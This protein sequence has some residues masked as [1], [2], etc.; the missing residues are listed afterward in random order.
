MHRLFFSIAL[1]LSTMV[2]SAFVAAA[3]ADEPTVLATTAYNAELLVEIRHEQTQ[4]G[5]VQVTAA[6]M[7]ADGAIRSRSVG[8]FPVESGSRNRIG[9]SV[10][11]PDG[12][13]EQKTDYLVLKIS[14]GKEVSRK[15]IPWRHRWPAVTS[16]SPP[17][18]SKG[19]Q[20]MAHGVQQRRAIESLLNEGDIQRIEGLATDW[21]NSS[22]HD[23]NGD[24]SLE[25]LVPTIFRY[26][27]RQDQTSA[28]S[29]VESWKKSFPNS[30]VVALSEAALWAANAKKVVAALAE[31]PNETLYLQLLESHIQRAIQSLDSRQSPKSA[32]W[33][34]A[35][36]I[37][38][39]LRDEN[40][41]EIKQIYAEGVRKYPAYLPLYVQRAGSA[42]FLNRPQHNAE[43]VRAI[44]EIANDLERNLSS[45]QRALHYARFIVQVDRILSPRIDVIEHKYVNWGK[46]KRQLIAL[47]AAFPTQANAN[48]L[49][50]FACRAG[51]K[52]LYMNARAHV[53]HGGI[54]D[55]WREGRSLDLCDHR[56][57]LRT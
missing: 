24:A 9:F 16:I 2:Q 22:A 44:D 31:N 17:D 14:D 26:M 25:S 47:R 27:E 4:Q 39:N 36:L 45:Q 52:Q 41:S 10:P 5:M 40:E 50:S 34:E 18:Y 42:N 33:Y 8:P 12:L 43:Y 57:L 55:L 51:D 21:Q 7:S 53:S 3:R 20:A 19:R 30:I 13:E 56:Y 35:R 37:I 23:R 29:R 15:L 28:R 1:A 11:A 49:A 46:L 54:V 32:P 6:L 48:L 38:A